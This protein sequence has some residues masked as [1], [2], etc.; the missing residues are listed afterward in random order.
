MNETPTIGALVVT[1][2][3][4]ELGRVAEFEG[5]CFKLDVR[6]QPVY[7]LTSDTIDTERLTTETVPLLFTRKDLAT[8]QPPNSAHSGR[9]RH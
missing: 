6:W 2:D 5:E 4:E 3:G 8:V 9:H 7:W 1:A